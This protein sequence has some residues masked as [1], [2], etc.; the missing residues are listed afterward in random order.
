MKFKFLEIFITRSQK[1][2]LTQFL[3]K[4]MV[5]P[6]FNLILKSDEVEDIGYTEKFS[7]T[8]KFEF[9]IILRYY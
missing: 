1:N 7:K 9:F 3:D 5:F 8:Y 4:G 2:L 6:W